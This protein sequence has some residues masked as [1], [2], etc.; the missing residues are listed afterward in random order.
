MKI[1]HLSTSDVKGGAA[2]AAY[3]VHSGLSRLGHE[4]S[5]VVQ[6][7]SSADPS[8]S[9]YQ[10]SRQIVDRLRRRLR[11]RKIKKD[12]ERYRLTLSCDLELFSDDRSAYTAEFIRQLPRCELIN[13]HWV[14]GFLDC[15]S[16]LSTVPKHTPVVWRLA[17]M[18]VLTGG[19]HYDLGCGRYLTSCQACPQLGSSEPQDLSAAIFERKLIA[20]RSVPQE[21]LHIVATSR[22]MEE[23]IQASPLLGRFGV[24]RIPNMIDTEVFS[25]RDRDLSRDIL[26]LPRDAGVVLFVAD[27]TQNKRK[28]LHL[29]AEAL[30]N[31]NVPENTILLSV[32][33]GTVKLSSKLRHH[34]LGAITQD[35]W[36]SVVYSAADV[37]VIPSIQEAFGQTVIESMACG[38]PVVGFA[39]GGIADSIRDGLTGVLVPP[40]DVSR[41]GAAITDL[42]T[43]RQKRAAMSE[44]CRRIAVSEYAMDVLAQRYEE[45]YKTLL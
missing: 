2:R 44:H 38:T 33:Y 1:V 16:F 27:N 31:L 32:G 14:S 29:L 19:C 25:P 21:R 5:M 18:N 23:Q 3:R 26:G 15:E 39:V 17:D 28:G 13:L 11:I 7:R 10:P 34:S 8:V 40:F 6:N 4:S 45:L 42:L 12:Y 30:D 36:L 22:W 35:R 41:M 43:D 20:F 9:A 24:T 37:Y